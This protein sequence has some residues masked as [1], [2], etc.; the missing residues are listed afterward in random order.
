MT[1]RN[2]LLALAILLLMAP[3]ARASEA[4]A[5]ADA[6]DVFV[7]HFG[8]AIRLPYEW[9]AAP[10]MQGPTETVRIYRQRTKLVHTPQGSGYV[11]DVPR[12]SDFAPEKLTDQGLI[13]LIAAPKDAPGGYRD[14]DDLRRA[15]ERELAARGADFGIEDNCGYKQTFEFPARSFQVWVNSPY[16][17]YQCYTASPEAFFILSSAD[18]RSNAPGSAEISRPLEM[19]QRSLEK[20]L[21]ASAPPPSPELDLRSF[22]GFWKVWLPLCALF[23]LLAALPGAGSFARRANAA[24]RNLLIFV[25]LFGLIGFLIPFVSYR[26]GASLWKNSGTISIIPAFLGPWLFGWIATHLYGADGKKVFRWS[27]AAALPL[28]AIS[29]QDHFQPSA[30]VTEIV[31]GGTL[32]CALEGAAFAL[33]LSLLLPAGEGSGHATPAAALLVIFLALGGSSARA[34]MISDEVWSLCV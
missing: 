21:R 27:W 20:Y 13:T 25:N 12:A 30:P 17:L 16:R 6:P 10:E 33:V 3:F 9:T 4:P 23:L 26:V 19:V 11:P 14:L 8:E 29:L 31:L 2:R 24:G 32:M 28:I 15:K 18:P 22:K 34:Q 1:K 5:P 7:G